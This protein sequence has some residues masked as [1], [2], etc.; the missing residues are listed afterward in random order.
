MRK[1]LIIILTIFSFGCSTNRFSSESSAISEEATI[2]KIVNEVKRNNLSEESFQIVK[3]TITVNINN[4]SKKYL[5]SLKYSKPDKYLIS[6][7]NLAGIEGIRIF[8]SADTVLANDRINKKLL[9]GK[10]KD[11]EKITGLPYQMINTIFGDLILKDGILRGD[12]T[13]SLNRIIVVQ[14]S[15]GKAW[16][17]ILDPGICKVVSTSLINEIS[18]DEITINYSKFAKFSKPAPKIIE[19][20]D[21]KRNIS[22]KIIIEKLVTPW[23]GEIEF[24]PGEG[25]SLDE[26]K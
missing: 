26:I 12:A 21:L 4:D 11:I 9:V 14:G 19:L 15:Y 13:R 5:F 25:Y 20:K 23:S 24:I 3:A 17:S 1:T 18:I 16:K 22:A 8:I 2:E 7:R 10:P 6:I